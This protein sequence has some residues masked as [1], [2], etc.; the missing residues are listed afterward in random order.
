M[1]RK[2]GGFTFQELN[3]TIEDIRDT[4]A[5]G[6]DL[7]YDF[8]SRPGYHHAL[9]TGDTE[10][11]RLTLM[12]S[13]ELGVEPVG[14]VHG[15][16]NH[17]ELTYELVHWA[18]LH[19]D[20]SYPFRHAEV[21]GAELAET[22][23]AELTEK[24]TG[25]ADYNRVFTQNGIACT[26]TSLIAA[27]QGFERLDDITDEA[28]P[29]I[30][31]AHL[32]LAKYNAWQPGVFAL[33]GWD[34]T[35]MLTVPADQVQ[36]LIQTGDTRW[37]ERGAHDLLDA[38]PE[39]TTSTSGMPRGRSL[40]G[41][42]PAQIAQPDSFVN[43]LAEVLRIRKSQGVAT[44]TQ[45]DVPHVAHPSML[46]LVHRLDDGDPTD[47]DARI[48]VTVLNFSAEPIDGTVHSAALT[49]QCSVIDAST[50][51][52]I[53]HVDDLQSFSVSL[54]PYGGLFLTLEPIAQEG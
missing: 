44:A 42:L 39:A 19:R 14:L 38:S 33:S 34:L 51:E 43:G 20:D 17:D 26:T 31:D 18:T 50:G 32:L 28:V 47:A 29:A 41:S 8:V 49:T 25:A 52:S 48:Q 23:R 21:T 24:L 27:T 16:Q 54:P 5:V 10:F 22:I 6:A 3:L 40:Y 37:I 2:V 13:L 11:L 36:D 35:G 1:V 15:M 30:R 9:A 7:S 46:V 53:G 4:S 45:L 12:T